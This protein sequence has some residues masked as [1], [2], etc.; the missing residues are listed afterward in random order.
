MRRIGVFFLICCLLATFIGC[1]EK[2]PFQYTY[3]DVFDTVTTLAL[4]ED[5]KTKA[6]AL[7]AE[8]HTLLTSLHREYTIYE[9]FE[10][11]VNVKTI[12]DGAG[13]PVSVSENLFSMLAFGKEAYRLSNGKV[14]MAMGSVLALWHT[15]RETGVLPV[16]AALADAARHCNVEKVVLNAED[17]TVCLL[18]TAMSLDVGAFAKGYAAQQVA[19]FMQEKG[20]A[21]AML[22]VG[23][24]V[25]TVGDKQG[26]P[27]T[28]GIED[29]KGEQPY[30]TTVPSANG[31]VVSS[32]DYQRFFTV[33]GVRY[34]HL[35]DPVT[36]Y[37][38]TAFSLVSVV[39]PDSGMADVLSTTLFL[40]PQAE[41][42]ALLATFSDYSAVWV[43]T[44]GEILYSEN[45]GK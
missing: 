2:T 39:G 29:P 17:R 14:N 8:I 41:G 44:Q 22:S 7:A 10:G 36:L 13:S 35:I 11:V 34:H 28:I 40:M 38:A 30:L 4:Y 31:A 27:F 16:E 6:D 25:V 43:D 15:A 21:S 33:D 12:N 5:D 24:N 23:G 45:F 9:D 20:I 18:D 3:I 37:P 1:G 19:D 42:K 26:T 32:G